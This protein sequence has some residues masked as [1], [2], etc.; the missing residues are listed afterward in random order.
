MNDFEIIEWLLEGDISIQYQV[1]RDL[2]HTEHP[3]LQ[4]RISTEGWGARLLSKKRPNGH[5]GRKFYQ[6]KW[7][8]SHYTLLDLRNLCISPNLSV[9]KE[10]VNLIADYEKGPDGGI[11]PAETIG[12]SDICVNGMFLN[13]ASYFG[14]ESKKLESV[15]DFI[16]SQSMLDGGFNCKK[17]R[18]GAKHSSLHSTISVL[19]G[20]E[21]YIRNGYVYRKEELKAIQEAANEFILMHRLYISDKTGKIIN[22]SFLRLSYPSRWR[23]D[24]LRALDYFRY[25]ETAWDERMAPAIKVLLKKQRKDNRWP[26]QAKHPGA[27]HFDMER[28]GFPSRWNTLR[29]MRVLHYF[30]TNTKKN[31]NYENIINS[32]ATD[33]RPLELQANG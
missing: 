30:D 24:I 32:P 20:V 12:K 9:A 19:E 7:T 33:F 2:L 28:A 29:A 13:Y 6:T 1:Y 14:L 15:V 4:N 23:Y 5:W 26:L 11:T 22:P 3:E 8:S 17:N 16:L 10:T 31:N 27:V 21:E 18:S 25:S